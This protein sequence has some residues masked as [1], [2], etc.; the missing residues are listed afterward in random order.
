V[1]VLALA[2]K[3]HVPGIATLLANATDSV[4]FATTAG[5]SRATGPF[6]IWHDLGGYLF[7]IVLLGVALLLNEGHRVVGR[8]TL[9]WTV[10]L[11]CVAL[12]STVTI[13]AILGTAVGVVV[14]AMSARPRRQW[15][16]RAAGFIA[17]LCVAAGPVMSARFAQQYAF[18]PPTKQIPY[19]PETLDFR[20]T[21]WQDL[22]PVLGRHVVTG[23]GPGVPPG[24]SFEWT[25]SVYVTVL[26][27]GGL[28]LLSL[29]AALMVAL[30]L[31]ARDARND[32]EPARRA[33]AQV[34]FLAIVLIVFMQLVTNYFV[35]AGFPFLFWVLAALL[36]GG[37]ES[38]VPRRRKP[39][40]TGVPTVGIGHGA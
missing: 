22:V 16:L 11:G 15:V 20:I 18:H 10:L 19:L 21:V 4:T 38:R 3:A 26:L 25:E 30:A 6:A 31:R 36:M 39:S 12:I 33:I 23:Y 5:L 14:M 13:T 17:L 32:P 40:A 29:Y 27:R 35:N 2:Q 9:V 24:L 1:S 34:L 7:V 37:I 28:P 8:R